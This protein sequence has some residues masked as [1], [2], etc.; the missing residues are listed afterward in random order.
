MDKFVYCFKF[1]GDKR[2]FINTF[3][4]FYMMIFSERKEKYKLN[5][6]YQLHFNYI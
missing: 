1:K 2:K 6:S 3:L 5:T 4:F